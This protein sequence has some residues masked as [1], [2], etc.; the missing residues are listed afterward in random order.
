MKKGNDVA[1]DDNDDAVRNSVL[2][3]R[4]TATLCTE[5]LF[6][7]WSFMFSGFPISTGFHTI[8]L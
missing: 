8:I 5:E 2:Q 1:D 6:P 7:S 4:V 3:E